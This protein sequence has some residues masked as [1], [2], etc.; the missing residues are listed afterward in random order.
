MDDSEWSRE[1]DLAMWQDTVPG[2]VGTEYLGD[3]PAKGLCFK[4]LI[5]S[6]CVITF[7]AGGSVKVPLDPM[8]VQQTLIY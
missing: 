6:C 8:V 1:V 3:C 2:L 7:L 5:N 4:I